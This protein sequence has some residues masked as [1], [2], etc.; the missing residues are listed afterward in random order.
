MSNPTTP[1]DSFGFTVKRHADQ[2]TVTLP[3]QC[4][5]WEITT[6]CQTREQSIGDLEDFI[7]EA[8]LA[9]TALRDSREWPPA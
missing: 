1:M 8:C 5:D 3:H 9:L 7:I 6:G 4:D 2:W